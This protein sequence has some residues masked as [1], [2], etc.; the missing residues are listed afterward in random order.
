MR[1]TPKEKKEIHEEIELLIDTQEEHY[2]IRHKL[3]MLM[4]LGLGMKLHRSFVSDPTVEEL[5]EYIEDY[6]KEVKGVDIK[7]YTAKDEEQMYEMWE[8]EEDMEG[9]Y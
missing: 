2:E 7:E 4:S 9:P 6:L 8:L 3:L 1:H 5:I